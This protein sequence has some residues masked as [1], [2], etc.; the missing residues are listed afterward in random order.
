MKHQT[1][2][3][4]L[5]ISLGTMTFSCNGGK[6][7]KDSRSKEEHAQ[8]DFICEKIDKQSPQARVLLDSMLANTTD[9]LFYYDLY[10]ELGRWYV[11]ASPDSI[12]YC[13]NR[14]LQFTKN[15]QQ[16]RRVNG[17]AASAYNLRANY[18]YLY[19]QN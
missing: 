11:L 7:E 10:C 4:L 9:S 16:T 5:L 2:L 18:N 8:I 3:A 1:L 14:I 19:H 6:E 15:Q 13:A 12:L 17:I